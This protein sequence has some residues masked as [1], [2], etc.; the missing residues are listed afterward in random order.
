[1]PNFD[2]TDTIYQH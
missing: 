1:M 2:F